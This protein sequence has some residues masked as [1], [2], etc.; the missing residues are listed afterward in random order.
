MTSTEHEHQHDADELDPQS[1][2]D[3]VESS[4]GDAELIESLTAERDAAVNAKLRAQ[5]DFVNYQRR[6]SENEQ[7]ALIGGMAAVVRTLLPALDNLDRALEMDPDRIT[8]EQLRDGVRMVRGEISRALESHGIVVIA[9]DAGDEFDPRRH[10]ALM[11][12]PSEEIP[13][14]H[15]VA[16]LQVG[17]AMG[18]TILR[19]AKVTLAASAE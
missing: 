17:Y 9:P 3:A 18:E 11:R 1:E 6:A 7:R 16:L 12:Q 4:D 2:S 14:D 19:P 15:V 13:A 8:V 10:E 5:A